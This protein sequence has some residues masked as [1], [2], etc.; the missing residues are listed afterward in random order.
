MLSNADVN[1]LMDVTP[2]NEKSICSLLNGLRCDLLTGGPRLS[3]FVIFLAQMKHVQ[4]IRCSFKDDGISS[5]RLS[6]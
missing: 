5:N 4:L 3:L 2:K 1:P 6:R